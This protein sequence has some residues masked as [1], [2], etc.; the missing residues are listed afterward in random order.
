MSEEQHL[1][2]N[3]F[4]AAAKLIAS[5]D[6]LLITA[7][8]GMGVDSGLPDFRGNEG[9]WKAYPALAD[10][11][12]PFSSIANPEAF[13]KKPRQAW[14]FYGHRLALYR[15]TIPHEGFGV[16][17][18]IGDHMPAGPFVITS[19]VDGQFQKAG[20]ADSRILEI[21][22]SIHRLQC[23]A[24][25]RDSIWSA[26]TIF[27]VIDDAICKW[28]G[29]HLP[30]CETCGR[31]ARPNILMFEDWGWIRTFADQQ[32]SALRDWENKTRTMVV[33]ELGAG[34]D[35]SSIRRIS[36]SQGCPVIRINCRDA[37]LREGAG[38][39]L[40]LRARDAVKAIAIELGKLGFYDRVTAQ[41]VTEKDNGQTLSV[42]TETEAQDKQQAQPPNH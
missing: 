12:I 26:H 31:L 32:R 5:A 10:A 11:K 38:I 19:N 14:G 39:S 9:F 16:L 30:T 21:H 2:S 40:P 29:R 42:L 36:E 25:C 23:L 35:I 18:K 34:T 20:F 17:K 37:H 15:K 7:G 28:V 22:G 27:P 13:K 6:G 3:P 24:N 41:P 4:E 1:N 33:I 8:A